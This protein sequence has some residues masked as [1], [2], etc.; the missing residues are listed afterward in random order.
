[1]LKKIGVEEAV[2]LK[3]AHDHT[4]IVA[5]KFKG[6]AFRRGHLVR[7]R[8]IPRLLDLGKKQVYVLE[9]ERG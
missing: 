2:G 8:D 3:L 6:A 1:M 9:L 4:R 5:G 7:K